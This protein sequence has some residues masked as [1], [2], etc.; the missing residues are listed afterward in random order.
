MK[1]VT[2]G[3]MVLV[4]CAGLVLVGIFVGISLYVLLG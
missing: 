4:I 1:N 3:E 2:K